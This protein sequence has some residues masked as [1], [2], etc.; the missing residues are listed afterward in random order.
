MLLLPLWELESQTRMYTYAH[1]RLNKYVK[2]AT[3]RDS[4]PSSW[5]LILV[6]ISELGFTIS[7]TTHGGRIQVTNLLHFGIQDLLTF[8][9]TNVLICMTRKKFAF[10]H[11]YLNILKHTY[12][13]TTYSW[14]ILKHTYVP[15]YILMHM[16]KVYAHQRLIC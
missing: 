15:T 5:N 12:I 7:R 11:T 9:H 8:Q 6:Y 4:K 10:K 3:L 13:Q 1:Q 2:I 14:N 16:R